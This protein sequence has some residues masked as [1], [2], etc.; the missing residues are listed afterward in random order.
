MVYGTYAEVFSNDEG[1]DSIDSGDMENFSIEKGNS[2]FLVYLDFSQLH[3]P[4]CKGVD[5]A[6]AADSDY[7]LWTP[8]DG[9]FGESKCF[10]GQHKTYTRRKQDSKCFNG[11][12]HESITRIDPCTCNEMDYECDIGY[13]RV[14]GQGPCLETGRHKNPENESIIQQE[15]W[16]EQCEEFGYYEVTQGYRKIPGDICEGGIDLAP[17]RYQ[18]NTGSYI[19]SFFTFRGFFILAVLSTLLYIGWP[20]LEA[21]IL[22]LPIPEP[23]EI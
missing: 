21:V 8:H 3:E 9:R 23:S 14:E 18:C 17:Y 4:Q 10:L 7:E 12:Q 2:A 20:L 19:V 6:D 16:N 11:E 5:T 22:L 15:V 13:T 1:E